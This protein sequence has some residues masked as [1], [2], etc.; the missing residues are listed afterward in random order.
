MHIDSYHF[1]KIKVDGK[2]HSNDVIIYPGGILS[3][4][5]RSEGHLLSIDDIK[6]FLVNKISTLIVGTG[7]FGMLKISPKVSEFCRKQNIEL[8]SQKTAKA[9]LTY[10]QSSKESTVAALHLTC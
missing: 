3:N 4:W 6:N 1:G 5:F 10:N 8:I 2:E 7:A 9:A